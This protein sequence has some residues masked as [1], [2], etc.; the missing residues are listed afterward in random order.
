LE[1]EVQGKSSKKE[2]VG[3]DME[4]EIRKIRETS[5]KQVAQLKEEK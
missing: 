2:Q 1:L 4:F 5:A 3:G